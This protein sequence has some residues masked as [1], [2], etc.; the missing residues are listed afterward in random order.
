[1]MHIIEMAIIFMAFM[2]GVT[3][4]PDV[5]RVLVFRAI[6]VVTL[7]ALAGSLELLSRG[8]P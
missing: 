2:V 7:L 1:M 5:W 8:C 3:S 6:V 4:R